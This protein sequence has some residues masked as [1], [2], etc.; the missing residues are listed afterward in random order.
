MNTQDS[1]SK[2]TLEKQPLT[3]KELKEIFLHPLGCITTL[4]TLLAFVV[5]LDNTRM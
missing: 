4:T 2:N 3:A 5:L 1:Q